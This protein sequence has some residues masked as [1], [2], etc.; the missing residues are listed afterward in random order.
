MFTAGFIVRE[1]AEAILKVENFVIETTVITGL[2]AQ[3]VKL[4]TELS[5]ELVFFG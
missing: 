1:H 5:D 3:V 4:L 2:A